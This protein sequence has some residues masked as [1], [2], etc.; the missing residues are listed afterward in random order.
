MAK[1]SHSPSAQEAFS[2]DERARMVARRAVARPDFPF[3]GLARGAAMILAQLEL[4]AGLPN[5]GLKLHPEK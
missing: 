2:E 3:D 4:S 1:L 5:P